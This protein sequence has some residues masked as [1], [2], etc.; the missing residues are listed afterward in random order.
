[1]KDVNTQIEKLNA[2]VLDYY[3]SNNADGGTLSTMHQKITG[4]LYFLEETRALIHDEWQ[5]KVF[6]LVG[7]GK[8]VSRAE[9][10]A[11]VEYPQ[12]YQLRRIMDAGYRV[13][14]SIRTRISYLKSEMSSVG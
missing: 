5:T 10:E 12:M 11:H 1:M 2:L 4:V 13:S 9:N 7:E 14:D 6:N 8:T 3:S